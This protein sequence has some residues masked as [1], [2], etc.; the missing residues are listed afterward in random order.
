MTEALLALC[1]LGI[2]ATLQTLPSGFKVTL[3]S[4]GC[5]PVWGAGDTAERALEAAM[6]ELRQRQK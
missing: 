4:R 3:S 6:K 5:E 1:R 2:F